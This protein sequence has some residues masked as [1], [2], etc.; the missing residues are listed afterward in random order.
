ML[1]LAFVDVLFLFATL[2]T[3]NE[4]VANIFAGLVL[5]SGIWMFVVVV[6]SIKT[7]IASKGWSRVPYE[8]LDTRMAIQFGG[9]RR[10]T[11]F[12]PFFRVKYSY[13]G[14]EYYRTSEED[15]NLSVGGSFST[16]AR[17]GKFLEDLRNRKYGEHLFV[18]PDNPRIAYLETGVRRDRYNV[19]VFS[20][21]LVVLPVLTFLGVI[22]WH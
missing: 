18:N 17:A 15:L 9:A 16:G 6:A 2:A 22:Q 1:I 13:A 4:Y 10:H 11:R 5:V 20:M 12:T 19:L 21:M 7:S 14:A 3:G 8:I